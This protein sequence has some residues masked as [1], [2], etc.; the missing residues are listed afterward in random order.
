MAASKAGGVLCH[1]LEGC[2]PQ[3]PLRK[4]WENAMR[5]DRPFTCAMPSGIGLFAFVPPVITAN[6]FRVGRNQHGRLGATHTRISLDGVEI[7]ALA[8]S[9]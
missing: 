4:P 3:A 8:F 7:S 1:Q 5:W 9:G 2:R 6:V